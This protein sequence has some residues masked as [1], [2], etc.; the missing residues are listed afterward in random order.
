MAGTA[1]DK[2]QFAID[3]GQDRPPGTWWEYN[4]SAIQ[5]LER[6]LETSTGATDVAAFAREHLFEPLGMKSQMGHDPSGNTVMYGDLQASCRDLARFGYLF[7][8]RGKWAD[9]K[10]IVSEAWVDTARSVSSPL[11]A[12]YGYLWWLNNPGHYVRPSAPNRVEGEGKQMERLPDS[13]YA[14]LGLGG[15]MVV[16]DSEHEIVMTRIGGDPNPLA[17]FTG[18]PDPVGSSIVSDLGNAL[19]DAVKD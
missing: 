7:L 19:G 11:N 5:T 9:G 18:N 3:L 8:R 17:A 1:A 15:Q 12:A 16:V 13:V 2:T 10:V 6:V 14:A 4:N